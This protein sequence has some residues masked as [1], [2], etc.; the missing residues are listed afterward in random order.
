MVGGQ[1]GGEKS[2]SVED[3][4][5]AVSSAV[6]NSL[7]TFVNFIPALV[8]GLVVLTIGLI[9]AAIVYRVIVAVF[10]AVQ[11]EKYL[12][13]Y[14]IT[15]V[16]GKEIEWTEIL[17][18]LAR[19]SIIIIFLI[20]TLAVWRL[21]AVNVVLTRVILYIPNVI[22][23]VVLAIVGLVF[24]KL[25][26]K[27]AYSASHNLGR[28]VAHTVALVAQWSLVVFIGF[29]VLYQL[30]VAQDL[31]RI[32]FMGLVAMVAIAGGLAFGLGGQG[33]AKSILESLWER[34]KK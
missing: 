20:P 33:T 21:G 26:Y 31:L 11:L 22:V 1:E 5:V 17:A 28:E 27:V 13:K 12:A 30:G 16:E 29:L 2:L 8:G 24:A 23:A 4:S 9:I 19:W 3:L 34:F 14:G 7:T 32:L 6:L 15:K 18:E 25:A 10:K